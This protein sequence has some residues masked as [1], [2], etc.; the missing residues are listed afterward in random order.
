MFYGA[1]PVISYHRELKSKQELVAKA[2]T[3]TESTSDRYTL[4]YVILRRG[5]RCLLVVVVVVM[6]V[7][8]V[9]A[10]VATAVVVVAAAAAATVFAHAA[11][12]A[13]RDVCSWCVHGVCS[14]VVCS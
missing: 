6:V 10:V 3:S 14:Y 2:S 11:A 7:A 12:A 13:I 4:F 1:L 8:V 9:V 5:C